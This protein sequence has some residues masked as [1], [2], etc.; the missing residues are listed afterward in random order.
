[1][2]WSDIKILI[3]VP[4]ILS[5]ALGIGTAIILLLGWILRI[6]LGM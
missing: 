2:S 1:M 4:I 6:L 5:F 3:L